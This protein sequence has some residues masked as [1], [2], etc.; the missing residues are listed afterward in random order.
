MPCLCGH[1]P[2]SNT[3]WVAHLR[4]KTF[5]GSSCLD[6]DA[7]QDRPPTVPIMFIASRQY[8]H[9]VAGH[10]VQRRIRIRKK[11]KHHVGTG[12][13]EASNLEALCVCRKPQYCGGML[14][15][16]KLGKPFVA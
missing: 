3:L 13:G 11:R 6:R 7:K 9:G 16:S 10:D 14:F 4:G 12:S 1:V 5:K 8:V 2:L 15:V